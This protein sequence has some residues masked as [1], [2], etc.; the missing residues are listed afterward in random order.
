MPDVTMPPSR[1][2]KRWCAGC[3]SPL[4]GAPMVYEGR[5]HCTICAVRLRPIVRATAAER[6]GADEPNASS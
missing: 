3:R 1:V 4:G 6:R 5:W 2:P